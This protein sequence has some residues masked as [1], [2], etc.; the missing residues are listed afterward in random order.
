MD[1]R[2][3]GRNLFAKLRTVD[4]PSPSAPS[5]IFGVDWDTTTAAQI[6]KF[7]LKTHLNRVLS[8]ATSV[9]FSAL[10]TAMFA[11]RMDANDIK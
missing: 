10:G 3:F 7:T 1:S 8:A 4:L 2:P 6:W 5:E 9:A 11:G